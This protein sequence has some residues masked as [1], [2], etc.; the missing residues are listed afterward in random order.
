MSNIFLMF[1]KNKKRTNQIDNKSQTRKMKN[2]K[3]KITVKK[4]LKNNCSNILLI[5]FIK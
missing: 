1:L 3:R 5:F 4:I 2:E